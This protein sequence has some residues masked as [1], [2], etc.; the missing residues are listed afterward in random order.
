MVAN[1]KSIT[2]A[3]VDKVHAAIAKQAEQVGTES[4][5]LSK[6]T[7][8]VLREPVRADRHLPPFNRSAMDG[9][10]VRS[11]DFTDCRAELTEV[12][13]IPAGTEWSGR[14]RKGQ[15]ARIMTGAPV[16]KGA[17]AVVMIELTTRDASVVRL[18]DPKIS[19]HS[20]V[21]RRGA[22]SRPGKVLL[23]PGH[24][25]MQGEIAIAASVGAH[26]LTLARP[27][28]IGVISTGREVIPPTGDP[29]PYQVR[30]ANGPTLLAAIAALP[31]C[32]GTGLGIAPDS[33]KPLQRVIAKALD[34][35]DVVLL[36]GGVSM[37]DLDLVPKVLSALGVR[38]LVHGAAIRPGKPLWVGKARGGPLVF[39]LPGNPVSVRVGFRE[40][41][42]PALRRM[43]G[44]A[45]ALPPSLSLPLAED[46]KKKHDLTAFSLAH[47]VAGPSGSCVATVPHE[48]SGD[49]VS[50]AG[51]DGVFVFP[52]HLTSMAA[53]EI[54][55][56]HAW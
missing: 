26:P 1:M 47:I 44:F 3:P 20:N 11:A 29:T 43:A 27:V 9:Y 35:C 12:A 56:F 28:T 48:G 53:G 18:E 15:C 38:Q 36:S 42:L 39:G 45:Q 50:A 7:G 52:A 16:P 8:R 13:D 17:N 5:S 22:D 34:R 25:L 55:E 54:V 37:G 6:A 46:V 31:W 10:A 41:V 19:P 49:F 2:L 23:R 51:S 40:F 24:E 30:D 32:K 4:V 33:E 14:L 21:H